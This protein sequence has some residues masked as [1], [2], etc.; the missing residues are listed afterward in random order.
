MYFALRKRVLAEH[1]HLTMTKLYNVLEAV[2][3]ERDLTDKEQRIYDDGLVGTLR[4][5]H[6]D[7]D[8]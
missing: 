5:I 2:R 6:D 4:S 7:I 8:L 3:E 1:E